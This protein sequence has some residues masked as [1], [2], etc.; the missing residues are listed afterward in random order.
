MAAGLGKDRGNK[1]LFPL[2]I[3]LDD[4]L[5]NELAYSLTLISLFASNISFKTGRFCNIFSF[6][7]ITRFVFTISVL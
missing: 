6:N 3:R 1:L 5:I 4:W 7:K 2:T